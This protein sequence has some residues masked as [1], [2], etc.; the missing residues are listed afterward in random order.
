MK[1]KKKKKL[2]FKRS[3]EDEIFASCL[4]F[5]F[6]FFLKKKMLCIYACYLS[7]NFCFPFQYL[8]LLF[9]LYTIEE[10]SKIH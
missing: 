5:Y 2:I 9:Y 7:E 10:E 4:I 3:D 8:Y 1:A 6:F